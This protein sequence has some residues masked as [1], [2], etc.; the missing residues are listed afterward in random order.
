MRINRTVPRPHGRSDIR[1]GD[2]PGIVV[3]DGGAGV[4]TDLKGPRVRAFVYGESQPSS[5]TLPFGRWKH[6]S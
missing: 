5:P 6:A 4:R 2:V 1:N 3:T